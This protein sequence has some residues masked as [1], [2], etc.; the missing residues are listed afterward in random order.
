MAARRNVTV[1]ITACRRLGVPVKP[2]GD[3]LRGQAAGGGLRLVWR[4]EC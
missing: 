4:A 3:R 2:G 1:R